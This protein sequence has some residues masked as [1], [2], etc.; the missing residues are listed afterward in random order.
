M[1]FL[2]HS[3]NNIIVD[4][5]LTDKGRQMLA[6]N[7]NS[8]AISQFSLGDDEVDYEVIRQFG[9]T[10]GKEKIA[11]NTPVFEAITN[12]AQ[13]LKYKLVSLSRPNISK[14]P[15]LKLGTRSTASNTVS[16][17]TSTTRADAVSVKQNIATGDTIPIELVDQVYQVKLNNNVLALSDGSKPISIDAD[18]TA[19]YLIRRSATLG[20]EGGSSINLRLSVKSTLTNSAFN[21]LSTALDSNLINTQAEV[22][23]LQSGQTFTLP[24]TVTKTS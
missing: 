22:R 9:R 14:M 12:G 18:G 2:D 13:G 21:T 16:L 20:S 5:V 15:T 10:V 24:V 6:R 4:A 19:T 17:N 3:T 1:G 8:F 7:D 23:G 11:K